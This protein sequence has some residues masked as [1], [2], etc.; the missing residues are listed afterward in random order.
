[1]KKILIFLLLLS[2][3]VFS[4]EFAGFQVEFIV[5]ALVI[6]IPISGNEDEYVEVRNLPYSL[7]QNATLY[8]EI[9]NEDDGLQSIQNAIYEI[10]L[11]ENDGT[12]S[13]HVTFAEPVQIR[14]PFYGDSIEQ[15]FLKYL[16]ESETPAFWKR[17]GISVISINTEENYLIANVMHFTK[18]S[19]FQYQDYQAPVIE[20]V[21]M[22]DR[23]CSN[24][25]M[26]SDQPKF[27][28]SVRD[29][30]QNDSGVVA[31]G[32][33]FYKDD[34][35][36]SKVISGNLA[37][38][39]NAELVLSINTSLSAGNYDLRVLAV[40]DAGNLSVAN[41]QFIKTDSLQVTNL[42]VGPN[43]VNINKS[44]IYFTYNLS[45]DVDISIKI[46]DVAGRK[47]KELNMTSGTSGAT[48]GTNHVSWNGFTDSAGKLSTGVYFVYLIADDGQ[49]K[50]VSKFILMVVK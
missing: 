10:T 15:V 29:D 18:F 6:Q 11:V 20:W 13:R 45:A 36:F 28:I 43:P 9:S 19:I 3:I 12:I 17:D 31:Y 16:D 35:M 50:D 5:E 1:M 32:V 26:I 42:L 37:N 46:F 34:Y 8:V 33:F 27:S 44:D 41:W 48:T 25:D 40:D 49:E 30:N 47:V 23:I 39:S 2:G 24:G 22:D 38:I 7:S 4:A 14:L 21:K